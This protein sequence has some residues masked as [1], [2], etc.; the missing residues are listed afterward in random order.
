MYNTRTLVLLLISVFISIG[1]H[2]L[3]RSGAG[4]TNAENRRQLVV[5]VLSA[6]DHFERRQA[7]RQTWASNHFRPNKTSVHFFLGTGSCSIPNAHR[8]SLFNCQPWPLDGFSKDK[9]KQVLTSQRLV[10]HLLPSPKVDRRLIYRGFAFLALFDIHLQSVGLLEC[11]FQNR[12]DL[13]KTSIS[14]RNA[15]T[16]VLFSSTI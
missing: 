4:K 2:L 6:R 7:I 13:K 12:R 10:G 16:E 14:L 15:M 3:L 1:L 11:S 8:R 5:A 9:G